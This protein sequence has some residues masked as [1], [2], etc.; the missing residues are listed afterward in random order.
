METTP[1]DLDPQEPEA[2]AEPEADEPETVNGP[3]DASPTGSPD[4]GVSAN[5]GNVVGG[6]APTI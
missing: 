3:E 6:G 1:D 4:D 2:P 5:E